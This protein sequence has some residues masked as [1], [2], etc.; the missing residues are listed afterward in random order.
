MSSIYRG[1]TPTYTLTFSDDN[2][3]FGD[4]N[5]IV[6]CIGNKS[7]TCLLELSGAD[8][9]VEEKT[10]SFSLSQEQTLA[11]PNADLLVQVNWTYLSGAE[12]KRAA[13]NQVTINFM[14]NLKEEVMA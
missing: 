7:K 14:K 11:L 2:L 12:L 10:I 13:S 6:V 3:D 9:T 1:T 5:E 4:A 8:L